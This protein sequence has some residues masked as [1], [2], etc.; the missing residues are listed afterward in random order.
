[1]EKKG[2]FRRIQSFF[3]CPLWTGSCQK[4]PEKPSFF[5]QLIRAVF[6]ACRGFVEDLCLLRAS[7]LTFYTLMSLV[8]VVAMLLAISKGFGYQQHLEKMLYERFLEQKPFLDQ[9][10]QFASNLLEDTKSNLIAGVGL[11]LLFWSVIK[12]LSHI[13]KALNHIWRV[14]KPR[15][16]ARRFTDFLSLMILAPTF[17]IIASSSAIYVV[18]ML[19]KCIESFTVNPVICSSLLFFI[20][21]VPYLLIWILFALIYLFLPNTKVK[22]S[23]ACIGGFIAGILYQL[24]QALYLYFQIGITQYGAVYGSFAAIPLFLIWIDLSWLCVLLG[25]EISYTYQNRDRFIFGWE[26]PHFSTS[27]E[28]ISYL[29]VMHQAVFHF[30]EGKKLTQKEVQRRLQLPLPF[31]EKVFSRLVSLRFLIKAEEEKAYVP[32]RKIDEIRI[33]DIVFRVLQEGEDDALF[34]PEEFSFFRQKLQK[35]FE[36]FEKEEGN[37]LLKDIPPYETR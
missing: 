18:T 36:V 35:A 20:R 8:P 32:T 28:L 23:A 12:M 29:W 14:K 10:I 26:P 24:I 19:Q 1:M 37:L 34:F 7:A 25:A 27:F 9:L 2:F 17:F 22:P 6:F 31:L 3:S 33:K 21:G 4:A 16:F 11:V 13:E 5:F 30:S 15:R